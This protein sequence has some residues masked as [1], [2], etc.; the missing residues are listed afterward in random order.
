MKLKIQSKDYEFKWSL[1]A[2]RLMESEYN[3]DMD[4]IRNNLG[5]LNVL[6]PFSYL[7]MQCALPKGEFLPF[8]EEEYEDFLDEQ[9][10]SVLVDIGLDYIKHVKKSQGWEDIE[11]EVIEKV[12]EST[13]EQ[14]AKKGKPKRSQK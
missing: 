13:T 3:M 14:V 8:S 7:A 12:N 6:I 11:D 9:K 1:K 2:Y 4:F 10:E 5:K